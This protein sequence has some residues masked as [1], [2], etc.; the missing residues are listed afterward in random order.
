ME[1]DVV[2]PMRISLEIVVSSPYRPPSTARRIAQKNVDQPVCQ[3]SSGFDEGE[4]FAGAARTFYSERLAVIAIELLEGAH[5]HIVDREPDRSAPIRVAAE[6]T[7]IRFCWQVLHGELSSPGFKH[8][9]VIAVI[10][11]HR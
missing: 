5:H 3:V 6:Q 7:A 2:A 8:V 10:G 4:H 9:R 11:R 1:R